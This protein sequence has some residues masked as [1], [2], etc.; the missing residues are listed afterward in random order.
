MSIQ[1]I[2]GQIKKFLAGDTPGVMAICGKW[3]VG[4]TYFWNKTIQEVSQ[5]EETFKLPRYGYVSLFGINSLAGLK[6]EIFTA[7]ADR[8]MIGRELNVQSLQ[9]NTK[10]SICS[11]LKKL[12]KLAEI[13]LPNSSSVADA[14]CFASIRNSVICIDDLERKSKSLELKDVLGLAS[15]LKEQKR[16][17]I[18]FLLNDDEE[19]LED[20]NKYHEKVVDLKLRFEP[21][22]EDCVEIALPSENDDERFLQQRV[23]NLKITNIRTIK[24]IERIVN[25]ATQILTDISPAIKQ[26]TISSLVLFGCCHYRADN[27]NIPDL[28]HVTKSGFA[29]LGFGK[30]DN[31][32]PNERKWNA[33]LQQYGYIHTDEFDLELLKGITNGYFIDD[34]LK[35]AAEK[36]N[37]ELEAAHSTGSFNSAWDVYHHNLQTNDK[38]VID[39]LIASFEANI[40]NISPANLAGLLWLLRNLNE[41]EKADSAIE[42][43]IAARDLSDPI[44]DLGTYAFGSEVTDK[45]MIDRFADIHKS[46]LKTE[47]LREILARI[48]EHKS[49]N[50]SDEIAMSEAPVKE[51]YDV[52]H[53]ED[54]Q[55]LSEY[56]RKCLQ[57]GHSS[58]PKEH[59]KLIS[60]KATE[61][62]K[63]IA[64]ESKVNQL[65]LKPYGI[66]LKEEPEE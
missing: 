13:A 38:E 18:V 10:A 26:Q 33:L 51:Y 54:G 36:K 3:G 66:T 41:D 39:T 4:K 47:S 55:H 8:E 2:E 43:Y 19:G 44:F 52:F 24:K 22:P 27:E 57:Y 45:K 49:W 1:L 28:K 46:S 15:V 42:A 61:A 56:I 7:I 48:T 29:R 64:R 60:E 58:A 6:S 23:C 34:D 17:K 37:A 50:V 31:T 53:T 62:L 21:T 25:M 65:R 14:V 35:A 20:F 59:E 16:C 32:P 30:E 5:S 63:L 12:P 11:V 9:E 40:K